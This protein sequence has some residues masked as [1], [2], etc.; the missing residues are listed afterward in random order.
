MRPFVIY[1]DQI[2]RGQADLSKAA[3]R[4][5]EPDGRGPELLRAMR[6]AGPWRLRTDRI[7]LHRLHRPDPDVPGADRP[8]LRMR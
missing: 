4:G 2:L 3:H 7:G 1:G 6:E 8:A 5:R